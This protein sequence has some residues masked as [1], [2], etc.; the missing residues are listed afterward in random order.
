[1]SRILVLQF[2]KD[3]SYRTDVIGKKPVRLL[4]FYITCM[5]RVSRGRDRMVAGFTTTYVIS[6]YHD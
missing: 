4:L 1:M 6:A 5:L 2:Y 3:L